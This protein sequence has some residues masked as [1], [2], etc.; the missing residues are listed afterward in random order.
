MHGYCFKKL[1]NDETIDKN[2]SNSRSKYNT[3]TSH[4][5]GYINVIQDQEIPTKYLLKKTSKRHQPTKTSNDKCRQ[6]KVNT[7]YVNY[8]ISGFP[9]MSVR[10]YLPLRHDLVDKSLLKSLIL[11]QNPLDKYKH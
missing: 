7:E 6:R 4:F 8:I 1:Q 2:V 3:I 9:Q 11:K 5:E 10:Y